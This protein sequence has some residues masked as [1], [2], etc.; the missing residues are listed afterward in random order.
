MALPTRAKI[1]GSRDCSYVLG[2]RLLRR[3]HGTAEV[4]EAFKKL[5]NYRASKFWYQILPREKLWVQGFPDL[6]K[7]I[8]LTHYSSS[9]TA[10]TVEEEIRQRYSIGVVNIPF[11]CSHNIINSMQNRERRRLSRDAIRQ[12]TERLEYAPADKIIF[13]DWCKG[14]NRAMARK[15]HSLGGVME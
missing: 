13:Y 9:I 8:W 2:V 3:W 15:Q 12:Y 14:V 7:T 5:F 10:S 6:S 11:I 4:R 1:Y